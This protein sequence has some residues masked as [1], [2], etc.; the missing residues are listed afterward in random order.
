MLTSFL[1]F[2]L[3]AC[4]V[5]F[6]VLFKGRD[7][8]QEWNSRPSRDEL[9][10]ISEIDCQI[11]LDTA[12]IL[13]LYNT[14]SWATHTDFESNYV[15]HLPGITAE[16]TSY[17]YKG[18]LTHPNANSVSAQQELDHWR[19]M[20]WKDHV[21]SLSAKKMLRALKYL[22]EDYNPIVDERN[23]NSLVSQIKNT[24]LER[25]LTQGFKGRITRS[26]FGLLSPGNGVS[27]HKDVVPNYACRIHIPLTTNSMSFSF[28]KHKEKLYH[29]HMK[30]GHCYLLN[31]GITHWAHNFGQTDRLHLVLSV[32]GTE[33]WKG[34]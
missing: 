16:Y 12:E 32:D 6:H 4:P 25:L 8:V 22:N 31:G 29:Y 5:D 24:Y 30:V 10:P 11:D 18:I 33:D 14:I 19:K 27:P 7:I 34:T 9:P 26:R 3:K 15:S 1:G 17:Y 20:H 2:T 21:A 28:A 23:H 13:R